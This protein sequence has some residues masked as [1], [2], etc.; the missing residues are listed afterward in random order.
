[1]VSSLFTALALIGRRVASLNHSSTSLAAIVVVLAL[2]GCGGDDEERAGDSTVDAVVTEPKTTPDAPTVTKTTP[3]DDGDAPVGDGH[4]GGHENPEDRPGGAGDEEPA[5][6]EAVLTGRG[7][8]ITPAVVRVPPFI[9]IRVELR[10]ADGRSYGLVFGGETLGVRGGPTSVST[11][12]D[13]LRPG[14]AYN[15]RP[16]GGGSPVRIE[17]SAEPGP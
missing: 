15:G 11:T 13:G 16:K 12:L 9:A 2:A 6:S 3:A 14:R 10:S 17:A 7:G 5:R 4:G 8:R 1:M